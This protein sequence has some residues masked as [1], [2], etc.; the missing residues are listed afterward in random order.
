MQNDEGAANNCFNLDCGGFHVSSTEYALGASF[1]NS[2][3]QI[4]GDL[5][6]VTVGIHRDLAGEGWWVSVKDQDIGYL[7]E[8]VFNTRFP[9]ACY[10]EMG[11]RVLNTRRRC[12]HDHADRW[13]A[14]CRQAPA[15]ASRLP[16]WH[17]MASAPRGP[18]STTTL[19]GPSRRRLGAT[20]LIL[21]V[22]TSRVAV[23]MSCMEVQ[24][25]SNVTSSNIYGTSE[26]TLIAR[27]RSDTILNNILHPYCH[28]LFFHYCKDVKLPTVGFV[29]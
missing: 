6:G 11:G 1:A 17:T 19:A 12:P 9:D 29:I 3:S 13:G 4:G 28:R 24:E 2:D 22:L 27:V 26:P 7:T 16:S 18:S 25:E 21:W 10:V 23:S 5:Y 15:G 14:G 8:S 20:E